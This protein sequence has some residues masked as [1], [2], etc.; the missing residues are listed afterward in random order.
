MA[1]TFTV[2][3]PVSSVSP[4]RTNHWVPIGLPYSVISEKETAVAPSSTTAV[5]NARTFGGSLLNCA[6]GAAAAALTLS[7]YSPQTIRVLMALLLVRRA[8]PARCSE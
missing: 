7:G 4:A 1:G 3:D 5:T 8:K 6:I 2:K